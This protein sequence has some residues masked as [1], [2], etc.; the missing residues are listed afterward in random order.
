MYAHNTYITTCS[1]LSIEKLSV[2]DRSSTTWKLSAAIS[3]HMLVYCICLHAR[4]QT[5][6][7]LLCGMWQHL[8][9]YIR[10][11]DIHHL[12]PTSC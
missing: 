4:I 6:A 12:H 1:Q 9:T 2:C 7:D 11:H 5:H 3:V 10:I 8:L